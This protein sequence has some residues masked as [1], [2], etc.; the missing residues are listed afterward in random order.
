MRTPLQSETRNVY[1]SGSSAG[2]YKS[3]SVCLYARSHLDQGMTN[4]VGL[5]AI[6]GRL[7]L[8]CTGGRVHGN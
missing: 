7:L 3:S 2:S 1:K 8:T 6:Q 4:T 5:F